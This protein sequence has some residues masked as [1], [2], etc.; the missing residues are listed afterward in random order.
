MNENCETGKIKL[1][2]GFHVFTETEMSVLIL[3]HIYDK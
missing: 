2:M 3:S 1:L